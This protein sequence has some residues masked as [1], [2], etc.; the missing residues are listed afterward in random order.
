MHNAKEHHADDDWGWT[1]HDERERFYRCPNRNELRT[2]NGRRQ[3]NAAAVP[4]KANCPEGE[5]HN[6]VHRHSARDA[7]KYR[8]QHPYLL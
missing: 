5:Q 4:A 6:D 8:F 1:G 2:L 3:E 7:S